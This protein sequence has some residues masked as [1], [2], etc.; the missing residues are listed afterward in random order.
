MGGP[1]SPPTPRGLF[2]FVDG[3]V[4]RMQT[5]YDEPVK[6]KNVQKFDWQSAA[7]EETQ[8]KFSPGYIWEKYIA[9]AINALFSK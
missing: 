1:E 4:K 9:P 2:A 3:K 8:N 6:P 7:L 5:F